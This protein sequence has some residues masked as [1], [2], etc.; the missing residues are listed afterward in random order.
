MHYHSLLAYL[1]ETAL[2]IPLSTRQATLHA[3]LTSTHAFFSFMFSIPTVDYYRLT[4]ISWSQMRHAL[5]VL[6]KLSSFESPDWNPSHVREI[7]DLSIIIQNIV[8]RFESI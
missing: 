8:S 7:L 5:V 2:S 6:Y 3:C 1:T 4:Y